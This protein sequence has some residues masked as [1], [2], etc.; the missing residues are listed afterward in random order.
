MQAGYGTQSDQLG[1]MQFEVAL[2]IERLKA[3]AEAPLPCM[4]N[5][6]AIWC[7]MSSLRGPLK[8]S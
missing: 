4:L 3:V 8:G 7:A 6:V 5:I 1:P 2:A